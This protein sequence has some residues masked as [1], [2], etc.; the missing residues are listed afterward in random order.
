[1]R[2]GLAIVWTAIC[3]LLLPGAAVCGIGSN[4]RQ[5]KVGAWVTKI[6]ARGILFV[7]GVRL[8]IEG[9]RPKRGNFVVSNHVTWLDIAVLGSA[10]PSNLI[11]KR[12]LAKLPGL[13]FCFRVAGTMF[14]NRESRRDAHRLA[15][16]LKDYLAAGLTISMFPEGGIGNGVELS[17][18]NSSLLAGAA[19]LRTPCVPAAIH[20][21]LADVIWCDGS[22]LGEHARRLMLAKW[23]RKRRPGGWLSKP[24]EARLRFAPPITSDSRKK[25]TAD[26]ES[27]VREMYRPMG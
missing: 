7:I 5:M 10:Y 13:G 22:S 27:A 17:K 14:I 16:E 21:D 9:P 20:Y 24:I 8:H 3:S 15:A 6:W 23:R 12:E 26:L 1:M 25:L 11:A 19:E 4:T 18:F 2:L